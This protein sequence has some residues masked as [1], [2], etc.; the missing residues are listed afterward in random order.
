MQRGARNR[1]FV[2]AGAFD[3]DRGRGTAAFNGTPVRV[4]P[5]LV[6]HARKFLGLSIGDRHAC[7]NTVGRCA[8]WRSAN[9]LLQSGSRIKN[10]RWTLAYFVDEDEMNP[11][12]VE[13][14]TIA[15]YCAICQNAFGLEN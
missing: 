5:Q 3:V 1:I 7:G 6:Q 10:I 8:E 4:S 15:P 14:G 13:R 2:V 11:G 12:R 9:N